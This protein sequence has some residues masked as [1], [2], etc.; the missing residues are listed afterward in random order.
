LLARVL[1][2]VPMHFVMPF[3]DTGLPQ[4]LWVLAGVA[5]AGSYASARQAGERRA[6][7]AE[8]LASAR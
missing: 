1:I 6:P 5:L 4:L 7:R 3:V 2:L 8:A